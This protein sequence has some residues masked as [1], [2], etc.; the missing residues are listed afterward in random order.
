MV[1]RNFPRSNEFRKI[2]AV[3]EFSPISSTFSRTGFINEIYIDLQ[4]R[5]LIS[6]CISCVH[7]R[8]SV[9]FAK[10]FNEEFRRENIPFRRIPR[11]RISR[12]RI[13]L[14]THT[15]KRNNALFNDYVIT[16]RWQSRVSQAGT[17][18]AI[19]SPISEH[20]LAVYARSCDQT[21]PAGLGIGSRE[22]RVLQGQTTTQN[23]SLRG[24]AST[25]S[26]DFEATTKKLLREPG[27]RQ[28]LQGSEEPCRPKRRKNRRRFAMTFSV[29]KHRRIEIEYTICLQQVAGFSFRCGNFE[30]ALSTRGSCATSCGTG[31]RPTRSC[32]STK[33]TLDSTV[34]VPDQRW[35]WSRHP[36]DTATATPSRR[37]WV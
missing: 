19:R 9:V 10:M 17:R 33:D 11:S 36:A 21:E 5:R 23:P 8:Y 15:R 32:R 34:K 29:N 26:W 28:G 22:W 1:A 35:R 18:G 31:T 3:N 7:H 30:S 20:E 16:I 12:N 27:D 4:R 25:R 37:D 2:R 24:R 6:D 14:K 13:I